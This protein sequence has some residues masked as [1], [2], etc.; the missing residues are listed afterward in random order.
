MDADAPRG[1]VS[2]LGFTQAQAYGRWRRTFCA[3][4]G[5]ASRAEH[6]H[7]RL[8][9]LATHRTVNLHGP[10][11]GAGGI[12]PV[13]LF[14]FVALLTLF[15]G[16][17]LGALRT[18]RAGLPLDAGHA[19]NALRAL[20]TGRPL[21]TGLTLRSGIPAARA[22]RQRKANDKYRKNSHDKSPNDERSPAAK[23]GARAV[24]PNEFRTH[25][26]G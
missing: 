1:R 8:V 21:R 13:S 18:L 26:R 2:G 19:L 10:Q 9:R 17:A 16:C 20:R 3:V 23:A 22:K 5:T 11:A 15:A 6:R 4:R 25:G 12:A 14:A 24:E 7:Q